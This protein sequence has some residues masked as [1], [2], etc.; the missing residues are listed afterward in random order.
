MDIILK[1]ITEENWEECIFLTT[2]KDGKATLVEEFVA[3]NGLS[4][5]QSTME[6]GWTI[7]AAYDNETMVGFTMYG[8]NH[9]DK[10]YEICRLMIDHK[11][12]NKGYGRKTLLKVIDE[13]KQIEDCK[14]I[15]ISFDPKNSIAKNLYMELGFKDTGRVLY[16]ELVYSLNVR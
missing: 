11:Y 16:D 7:K 6:K 9:I 13:M 1:D 3:S 15:M 12:Q 5:V 4:M 10:F 8:Y 14:D 2:N